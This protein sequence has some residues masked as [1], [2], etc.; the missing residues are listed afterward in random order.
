MSFL[1]PLSSQW[2]EQLRKQLDI[3]GG[4]EEK[5]IPSLAD[6]QKSFSSEKKCF[7]GNTAKQYVLRGESWKRK[8]GESKGKGWSG[9]VEVE[10]RIFE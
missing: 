4:E 8:E 9:K 6:E 2:Q 1:R 7:P 10:L 3:E 5:R